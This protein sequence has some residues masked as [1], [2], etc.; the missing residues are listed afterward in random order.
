M[1]DSPK[2]IESSSHEQE[3]APLPYFPWS[4]RP[5][6]VP[7]EHDEAATALFLAHGDT[8]VAAG[9]LKVAHVRLQ[10]LMRGSP[11]L[12][13]IRDETL[14]EALA[15][16]ESVPIQTLFD[17]GADA[18]RLEWA[19]TKLLSSRLGQASPLAPAPPANV[20]S[21]I[22][23]NAPQREIVFRWKTPAGDVVDDVDE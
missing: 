13:R 7:L 9:L 18:R 12:Q 16:A 20:Q 2:L 23:I 14:G 11:R 1:D 10:R 6:T 3:F 19:S 15:R 5:E 4:E 22:A 17:P 8:H 21:S